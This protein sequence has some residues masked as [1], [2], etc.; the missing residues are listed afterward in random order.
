MSNVYAP[1]Q[2]PAPGTSAQPGP[3]AEPKSLNTVLV[4]L[5]VLSALGVAGALMGIVSNL[6]GLGQTAPPPQPGMPPGFIEAQA[7]M[8]EEL[9]EASMKG[10]ATVISLIAACV[11]GYV[12]MSAWGAKQYKD[13]ARDALIR[14]ALPVVMAFTL[15]KLVW[16]L[17]IAMR[18]YTVFTHF[19]ERLQASM[20]GSAGTKAGEIMS[21]AV[22]GGTIGGALFAIAWGLGLVWFYSWSRK[23]LGRPE[24]E[25]YFAARAV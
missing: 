1:P 8:Y 20:P 16:G 24:V 10:P 6:T 11:E 15:L 19:M 21:M 3:A 25:A 22:L 23:V 2:D 17:F 7:K 13:S 5:L 14:V 18:T 9:Q 12:L 4:I